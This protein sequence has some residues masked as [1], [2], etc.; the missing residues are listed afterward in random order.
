MSASEIFGWLLVLMVFSAVAV[1]LTRGLRRSRDARARRSEGAGADAPPQA[2]R[3]ASGSE[4]T[5]ADPGA[6]FPPSLRF[7]G[8]AGD[9][10]I[11]LYVAAGQVG[12]AIEA[13]ARL[14]DV[15]DLPGFQEVITLLRGPGF[16]PEDRL[17][18]ATGEHSVLALAG[19]IALEQDEWDDSFLH[20]LIEFFPQSGEWWFV[21]ALRMLSRP[22]PPSR[23][24]VGLVLA[25]CQANWFGATRRRAF[26][27]FARARQGAGDPLSFLAERA[28]IEE[29]RRQMVA[30]FCV[31]TDPSLLARFLRSLDPRQSGG[32][33]PEG[34]ASESDGS[35]AETAAPGPRSG[36]EEGLWVVPPKLPDGSD[37][38]PPSGEDDRDPEDAEA[39][40][41]ATGVDPSDPSAAKRSGRAVPKPHPITGEEIGFL[42]SVGR[43]SVGRRDRSPGPIEHPALLRVVDRLEASVQARPP[44]CSL[45]VGERGVG[46]TSALRLLERR[47]RADGWLIFRAGHSELQAG[48]G[49]VGSLEERM[50]R[51]L[52]IARA[53]GRVLWEI[54]ELHVLLWTGRHSQNPSLGA[55]HFLLAPMEAGEVVI[56][57]ETETGPYERMRRELPGIAMAMD[58]LV[59]D[60]LPPAETLSL[61]E[62]W[63][64]GRGRARPTVPVELVTEAQQLARQFLT[65]A[66][67]PG[68]LLDLL[69]LTISR[70]RKVDPALEVIDRDDLLATVSHLT[71][72]PPVI[73]DE[74][75]SLDLTSLRR[76][77]QA[78]VQGQPEAVDCLTE[79]VAMVKA[80]LCD[81]RRPAGVFLFAGPTGTGKTAMAKALAEWLFGS[82]DRMIRLDM[83]ELTGAD[84]LQRILGAPEGI[85][86]SVQSNALVHQIRRQPFSVVLLDEIE[87]TLPAVW[88]LFLQL[89]DDGRLTDGAGRTADF[90]H[91]IFIMTSNLGGF[92]PSGTSLGFNAETGTFHPATVEREI[93]RAFRKEFLNRIDRIVI[94]RPLAREVMRSILFAQLEEAMH[95][96]G[97]RH[98]HWVIE[99]DEAAI[100]FLLEKGFTPDLG[101]RPLKRAVERYLL[102]PLAL[103]IVDGKVPERNPFLLI[104][105]DTDRLE[106]RLLEEPE[107]G[108]PVAPR[109][110]PRGDRKTV[111]LEEIAFDPEGTEDEVA[112]LVRRYERLQESSAS[113]R[114]RE[115]REAALGLMGQRGFW[116]G[117]ERFGILGGVEYQERVREGIERLGVALDRLEGEREHDHI[118]FPRATVGQLAQRTLLLEKAVTDVE[119]GRARQ[120]FLLIEPV[121]LFGP[122]RAIADQFA[123]RLGAMYL[124]WARARGMRVDRLEERGRNATGP[125]RLL[126]AISGFAAY[127][128][129]EPEDGLHVLEVPEESEGGP[130]PDFRRYRARVRVLP[131]PDGP[132][133]AQREPERSAGLRADAQRIMGTAAAGDPE[134]VRRYRELPSPLVRDAR[135]GWRTGRI[136]RVLA[137]EFDLV[138]PPQ[139]T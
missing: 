73:L 8:D 78:R 57:G 9:P 84:A 114:W 33:E 85:E 18:Y 134:V 24:V 26:R 136:D 61:A 27:E 3:P 28:W 93:G 43:V 5:P 95:R 118:V 120:A 68:N 101:A 87:K 50:Q 116:D 32:Y 29:G 75:V 30:D 82:P 15:L 44:R 110:I 17:A 117:P 74:R 21:R 41:P 45:L 126:L 94:F 47:L 2:D 89:F 131:M 59:L 122:E 70:V 132:A 48:T 62:A 109:E 6:E 107:F 60:P 135:R 104:K 51:I 97:L 129:L 98:R 69:D 123:E 128:V 105:A 39:E 138:P 77:F 7:R 40:V 42:R 72:L 31:R 106:V 22:G 90:R 76:H 115:E 11:Q 56:V 46:K 130:G 1:G 4:E 14:E 35:P 99:W 34:A 55:L 38:A 137:G 49:I 23:P 20:P 65:D 37:S 102:S 19:L 139:Q 58:V 108:P 64:R 111:P 16:T 63:A 124:G 25:R 10:R 119:E 67:P 88:D 96:R 121:M 12:S 66:Q 113:E 71:G 133:S 36:E 53:G 83:S 54:P 125:Y 80:G 79:R 127:S 92:I 100:D 81:P 112:T 86:S 13:M 52:R 91:A 103:A